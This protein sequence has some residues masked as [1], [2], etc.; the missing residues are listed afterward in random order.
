MRELLDFAV[1]AAREA[2]LLTLRYFGRSDLEVE[3]NE[4]QTPVTAADRGAE[5]LLRERIAKEFPQDG[6]LGEEYGEQ[7]GTSGRRWIVDPVDGTVSFVRGVPLYGTLVALEQDGEAVVGVIHMPVLS[8]TAYA[9]V[10]CGAWWD[11][12][13]EEVAARVSGVS[14]PKRAMFCTTSV[15]GFDRAGCPDL[16]AK[17]RAHLGKDR[18]W[19]DCYGHLLVATGRID[20]MVDPVM[21]VWDCAALKPVVEEA[22]GTFTDLAGVA[23][24][25]GGSAVSSNG[26]LHAGVLELAR[27]VQRG[28]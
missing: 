12:G 27:G 13:G 16:Y 26:H 5:E 21:A 8:E 24:H 1:R 10:G 18:G 9:A 7:E 14:D 20:V 4:N 19:S 25:G 6:I 3:L 22:G 17:L 23:T 11:R 2:G 15:G 28:V